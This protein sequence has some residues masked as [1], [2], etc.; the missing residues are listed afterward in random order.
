MLDDNTPKDI[1]DD[2]WNDVV[3]GIDANEEAD[4]NKSSAQM[5]FERVRELNS[6]IRIVNAKIN[7]LQ[8]IPDCS[9][10]DSD[11]ALLNECLETK[12]VLAVEHNKLFQ[13]AKEIIEKLEDENERNVLEM[14]YLYAMEYDDIADAMNYQI[15]SI[16]RFHRKALLHCAV[17]VDFYDTSD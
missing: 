3:P 8:E 16:Y 11:C 10:T 13:K 2:I 12:E 7:A 17:Y 14:R 5:F 15:K 4:I 1:I 6:R 9:K